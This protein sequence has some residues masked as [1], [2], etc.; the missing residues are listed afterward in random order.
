MLIFLNERRISQVFEQAS[1]GWDGNTALA[2][3]VAYDQ[4]LRL[5]QEDLVISLQGE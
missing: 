1:R 2:L 3:L 5:V 4:L